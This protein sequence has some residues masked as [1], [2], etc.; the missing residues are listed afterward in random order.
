[1]K[2]ISGLLIVA[3]ISFTLM[4]DAASAGNIALS[5]GGGLSYPAEA[6][7]SGAVALDLNTGGLSGAP[8]AVIAN[9]GSINPAT[10]TYQT[11][12]DLPSS[13]RIVFH[14]SNGTWTQG[15]RYYLLD[16]GS[17]LTMAASDVVSGPDITFIIGNQIIAANET[18]YLSTTEGLP[19]TSPTIFMNSSMATAGTN[20]TLG[21]PRCYDA[22]GTIQGCV[23]S[24]FNLVGSYQQFTWSVTPQTKFIDINP[25]SLRRDFVPHTVDRDT[26]RAGLGLI[27]HAYDAC[28]T[29]R[30]SLNSVPGTATIDYILNN[31]NGGQLNKLDILV[32]HNNDDHDFTINSAG[33]QATLSVPAEDDWGLHNPYIDTLIMTVNG[34]DVLNPDTFYIIASLNFADK[35]K[36]SDVN[37]DSTLI[38]TWDMHGWLGTVPYMYASSVATDDTFVKIFNNT[39]INAVVYSIDADVYADVTPD[40]GGT[41]YN[42]HIGTVPAGTVGIFWAKAIAEAA[43]IPLNSSFGAVFAVTAPKDAVTAMANQKLPGGVDRAVPVY[44]GTHGYKTY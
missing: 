17:G 15:I 11:T 23:A 7:K 29:W 25:P 16:T 14:L 44:T 31:N 27:N 36:Y 38:I 42:V 19:P 9:C 34:V 43:G 21:V 13:A 30:I 2:K 6:A 28:Y 4:T 1:M 35:T 12:S 5:A 24:A 3:M 20:L 18:V 37:L 33:T 26:V 10:I 39:A 22:V 41:V 32:I 8:S 40:A